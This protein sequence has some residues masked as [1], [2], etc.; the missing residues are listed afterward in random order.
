MYIY[1]IHIIIKM[2]NNLDTKTIET[3]EDK[4]R[5]AYN[6]YHREYYKNNKH[7]FNKHCESGK[8]RGKSKKLKYTCAILGDD[9]NELLSQQFTTLREIGKRLKLSE[10]TVQRIYRGDFIQGKGRT[11]RTKQYKKFLITKI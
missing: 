1:Y 5:K 9:G 4:M 11:H 8:T 10:N 3:P 6:A 7:R 2:D